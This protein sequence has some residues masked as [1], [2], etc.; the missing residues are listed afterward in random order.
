MSL[1]G[2]VA[3]EAI[4]CLLDNK[5]IA[6]LPVGARNDKAVIATQFRASAANSPFWFDQLLLRLHL[7]S[8]HNV[9]GMSRF[10]CCLFCF[11]FFRKEKANVFF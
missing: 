7:V 6:A 11:L 1:R 2:S 8:S 5:E 4:S 3:T 9:S 10:N